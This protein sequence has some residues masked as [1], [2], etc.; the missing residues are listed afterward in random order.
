MKID[1]L[2]IISVKNLGN[3]SLFALSLHRYNNGCIRKVG[4]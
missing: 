2:I 3:K 1:G 4:V